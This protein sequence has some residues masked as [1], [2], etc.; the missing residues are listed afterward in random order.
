MK[1]LTFFTFLYLACTI[2]F[3]QDSLN[4]RRNSVWA[5]SGASAYN[6]CWGYVANG[7][8]YA[9]LGSNWGTHFIDITNPD[10]PIS[11]GNFVGKSTNVIWRDFK[12]FGHYAYGVADGAQN[13]LQIFDLQYLPDSV[14]KIYDK[15]SLSRSCHNIFIEGNRLY[16]AS[17]TRGFSFYSME[18]LSLANPTEPS[19]IGTLNNGGLFNETHDVYVIR[20]TAFCSGGSGGTSGGGL[21][22]YDYRNP[23]APVLISSITSYPEKGYNHSSWVSADRRKLV[24]ADETHGSALKLYNISDITNPTLMGIFR[25]NPGAIVHNPYILGDSVYLS[26]YHDGAR[27]FSIADSANLAQVAYFDTYPGN[28]GYPGF[29]GAW[30]IYPFLP[31]KT[32]IASDIST[33]LHVLTLLPVTTKPQ[34]SFSVGS[35]AGCGPYKVSVV[36]NS[37]NASSVLWKLFQGTNQIATFTAQN[38][39]ITINSP[40]NYQLRL[41]A[42]N[43]IGSDSL[44]QN[45]SISIPFVPSV[46]V[47]LTLNSGLGPFCLQKNAN[48]DALLAPNNGFGNSQAIEFRGGDGTN[49]VS[50]LDC[51][52]TF[53]A[54]PEYI[55]KA[56]LRINVDNLTSLTMNYFVKFQNQNSGIDSTKSNFRIKVNG[57]LTSVCNRSQLQAITSSSLNLSSFLAP[58]VDTL[59]IE[60]EA[61]NRFFRPTLSITDRIILDQISFSGVLGSTTGLSQP[62]A[63]DLFPNPASGIVSIS[64]GEL[65]GIELPAYAL[66]DL[67][68]KK[69]LDGIMESAQKELSVN[70]LANGMYIMEI[71][72]K[73]RTERKSLVIRK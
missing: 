40:G 52:T 28:I 36:N 34:V 11:K 71:I 64:M 33:G 72:W 21:F 6:D 67:Q 10:Q 48:S 15:D 22:I 53:A 50:G 20:D 73:D 41:I 66:Y 59:Y 9:I 56:G 63:V 69:H 26:Y 44:N 46:P 54:N 38:P 1:K 65:N 29:E 4:M 23:T 39:E 5:F 18:I 51:Q 13:S 57:Q 2:S 3:A 68:G 8:E 49:F 43:S 31:S 61:A 14:V 47:T 7:R 30:G 60:F 19:L 27:V 17:N 70:H 32:I 37:I 45:I 62:I 55:A 12:T 58:N 16:M 35:V 25:S 24:F 42:T